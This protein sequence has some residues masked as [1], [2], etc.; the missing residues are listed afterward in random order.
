M[1]KLCCAIFRVQV[2]RKCDYSMWETID[3]SWN[4][5]STWYS[6]RSDIA[7]PFQDMDV[8]L[9]IAS[10]Q[11]CV[12]SESTAMFHEDGGEMK[13]RQTGKTIRIHKTEGVHY[14]KLKVGD[15]PNDQPTTC[16]IKCVR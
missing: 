8:E 3:S 1:S 9:P 10:V 5:H 4:M 14:I 15:V 6:R 11:K 7:I 2:W 16:E 13:N 12:K